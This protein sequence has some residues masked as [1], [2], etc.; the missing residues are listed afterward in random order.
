MT[1]QTLKYYYNEDLI[2]NV[3][4]HGNNRRIFDELRASIKELEEIHT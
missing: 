4:R 2:P 1:Y 3:K